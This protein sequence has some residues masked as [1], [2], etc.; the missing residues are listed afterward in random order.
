M[1]WGEF[2]EQGVFDA[3]FEWIVPT[4]SLM[5]LGLAVGLIRLEVDRPLFY[6]VDLFLPV[7]F[8]TLIVW[9]GLELH[10]ADLP[11]GQRRTVATWY[12]L[13]IYT[14]IGLSGWTVLLSLLGQSSVPVSVEIL[15]EVV[16]GGFFGLLVGI[17]QVRAHQNAEEA[18]EAKLEQEFLERQQ[19]TNEVLNRI[20]RH[21]LLNGL[22]VIQGQAQRLEGHVDR[23]G[24][25]H[26]QRVLEEAGEMADTIEEIRKITRT[27][28]EDPELVPVDLE[29]VLDTQLE[30]ARATYPR[31]EFERNGT[32]PLDVAVEGNE[33]IGRAVANVLNNAVDHNTADQPTV[34]VSV[35]DH[36]D[37][38]ELAVADNGPG[39]PDDRKDLVLEASERGLDSDGEG[40]GFFLTKSVLRQYGGEVRVA[41]NDPTGTVVRLRLPKA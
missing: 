20:L 4:V 24:E 12:A 36:D 23:A 37:V 31:A 21:H 8:V 28:T 30:R 40:L 13:G 14:M 9:Q 6:A 35:T 22:T 7:L 38:V 18:T 5:L 29:A 34:E 11:T 19:E 17:A 16:A 10:E 26:R 3:F 33:L 39:I 27:L 2:L 41:D 15:T 32:E 25:P 1:D